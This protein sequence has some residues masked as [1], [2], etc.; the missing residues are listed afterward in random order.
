[1]R[2]R[3]SLAALAPLAI[4][5]LSA[6]RGAERPMGAP[7]CAGFGTCGCECSMP[8]DAGPYRTVPCDYE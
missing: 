8:A 4:V 5:V 6:C 1:M 2:A 3:P 7:P